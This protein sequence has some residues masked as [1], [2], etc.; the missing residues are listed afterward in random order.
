M[1]LTMENRF[2]SV[3]RKDEGGRCRPFPSLSLALTI[4]GAEQIDGDSESEL[5]R[6]NVEGVAEQGG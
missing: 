6:G 2:G 3:G 5:R 4:R 1:N